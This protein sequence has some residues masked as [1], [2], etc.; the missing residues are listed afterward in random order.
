M[1]CPNLNI[2]KA[3]R[4]SIN[5]IIDTNSKIP[6]AQQK[7]TKYLLKIGFTFSKSGKNNLII[8]ELKNKQFIYNIYN[9]CGQ[10]LQTGT[11]QSNLTTIHII[12]NFMV[13]E[14]FILC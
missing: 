6:L 9:A 12:N 5:K 11:F 2:G 10:L 8:L 7:L 1:L 3:L 14:D 4:R 13:T